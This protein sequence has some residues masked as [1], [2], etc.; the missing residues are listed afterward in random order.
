MLVEHV[1]YLRVDSDVDA[2]PRLGTAIAYHLIP[3]IRLFQECHVYEGYPHHIETEQKHV[4]HHLQCVVAR[5][6]E[7]SH[8]PQVGLGYGTFSRLR[9]P[10]VDIREGVTFAH[11]TVFTIRE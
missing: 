8:F 11:H 6:I 4:T 10:C 7:H 9:N 1:E 5:Q 3:H 2:L